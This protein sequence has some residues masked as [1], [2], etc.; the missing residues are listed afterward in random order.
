MTELEPLRNTF[1]QEIIDADRKAGRHGGRVHT[2]FPPEPN[3]YLHIGHAKSICLNFG[4]AERSTAACAT[5]ASTTPTRPRKSRSTSR[6]SRRTCAGWASTGATGMYYASRLLRAAVRV[7]RQADQEGQGVRLT[8]SAAEEIREYRGTLRSPGRNSPYR[9]RPVE[10]NLDLFQRMREGEFPDGSPRPAG[11]DRH[12]LAQPQ[13]AR[14]GDVP[15]PARAPPPH[16]RQVV[17]LPDVRLRPPASDAIE[18]ITHSICTLEFEDHRPL[19]DW[20]LE[21]A[22][23]STSRPS[24]SSSPGSNLTYTVTQQAQAAASW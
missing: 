13:H 22:R 17:H 5:C 18:G 11:Q 7:R 12:G 14:P 23:A 15:H 24:R 19:Y 16:G 4:L 6:P 3:G 21:A 9:D 10:E 2:R 20:F 1:I 8:T